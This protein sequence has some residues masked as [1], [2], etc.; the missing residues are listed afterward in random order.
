M[1]KGP[2]VSCC[3]KPWPTLNGDGTTGSFLGF[4]F[5]LNYQ[6]Q[7]YSTVARLLWDLQRG[8]PDISSPHLVP[9]TVIT[10]VWTLFSGLDVTSLW[11]FCNRPCVFL[12]LFTVFS[13]P[14]TLPRLATL[15]LPSV[16]WSLFPCRLFNSCLF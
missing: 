14:P 6:F 2:R 12:C 11:R 5:T 4:R 16:S 1:W 15:H 9:Y 7:G 10:I 13:Q 3:R 8:P